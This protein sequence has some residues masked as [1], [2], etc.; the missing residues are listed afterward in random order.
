MRRRLAPLYLIALLA[1]ATCG[2][3]F[4]AQLS[5]GLEYHQF[6]IH[7]QEA[8]RFG[9]D[10]L[11]LAFS[12][13]GLQ[14]FQKWNRK[15]KQLVESLDLTWNHRVS[16]SF[17][18]Q[19]SGTQKLYNEKKFL[20]ELLSNRLGAG[21][22]FESDSMQ[23]LMLL[24]GGMNERRQE[25]SDGGVWWKGRAQA[26]RAGKQWHADAQLSFLSESPGESEN[27]HLKS[28]VHGQLLGSA[29]G[30]N[31]FR[32]SFE[33]KQED[34]FPD[35]FSRRM[36]RRT[37]K[38][39]RLE[40]KLK[41]HPFDF[42][43]FE[44][45]LRAWNRDLNREQKGQSI[46]R[47]D[48]QGAKLASTAEAHWR[49]WQSAL[50]FS[51]L[52]QRQENLLRLPSERNNLTQI[53]G[54]RLALQLMHLADR[55]TLRLQS[56]LEMRRRDS[57]Y[58]TQLPGETR[59]DRDQLKRSVDLLYSRKAAS[60]AR[61]S[62]RAGW[63]L[64][65]NVHLQALRSA[66]NYS[67][68]AIYFSGHHHFAAP[69]AWQLHGYARVSANYR[70]YQHEALEK[71]R[72]YLQRRF[73]LREKLQI[74]LQRVL[75]WRLHPSFAVKFLLEDGGSWQREL[76]KELLSDSAKELHLDLLFRFK[77]GPFEVVPGLI[78][79]EHRDFE[80]T[81]QDGKRRASLCRDLYRRGPVLEL[82][83]RRMHRHLYLRMHR[84]LVHDHGSQGQ[85]RREIQLW[86][87]LDF[88]Y[89][90]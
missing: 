69:I 22:N 10:S 47:S 80:W 18:W 21:F 45:D 54:N 34:F 37:H 51:L 20:R 70:L 11:S 19:V 4:E 62:S 66:N 81:L 39:T 2:Y 59:D 67:D 46:S 84:E 74:R 63:K 14:G 26:A 61:L 38:A 32:L 5:R 79:Y 88:R 15:Q 50:S 89:D 43:F 23:S 82:R 31:D 6:R 52:R 3:G 25:S 27:R 42:L 77:R 83:W 9:S 8:A 12:L 7:L 58:S 13:Q 36:E 16:T 30:E 53:A 72:S 56:R 87:E 75:G 48:D 29:E 71:P 57:R 60:W 90:F 24:A 64:E 68:K 73:V 40:N 76:Q 44:L 78:W 35:P 17:S 55:D 1:W 65:E 33:E 86:G 28:S 85:F 49:G 41:L